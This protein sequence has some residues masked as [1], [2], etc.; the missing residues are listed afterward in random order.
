MPIYS[1]ICIRCGH[2]FDKL[3]RASEAQSIQSCPKCSEQAEKTVTA[4]AGFDLKG[5]GWYSKGNH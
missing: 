3:I 4:P 2:G 5:S 1:Y